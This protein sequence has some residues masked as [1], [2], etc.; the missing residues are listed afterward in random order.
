METKVLD[1]NTRE[2]EEKLISL[3]AKKVFDNVR[4]ITHFNNS[5]ENREP[6][7]KL[8]EE[9]EKL[10]L[11]SQNHQTR[12]E[13]KLFVSRKVECIELLKT[14]GYAP[15]SEVKVRRISFEWEGIDFD[16]DEFP[17]IPA[18]LE[19]DLGDSRYS[20]DDILGKL[21]LKENE[22]GEMSTIDIYNNYGLNYFDLF[23]L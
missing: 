2:L 20:L 3:G 18:F 10:K 23:K 13:T 8:T 14:L 4:V 5:Q 17:Q 6:F 7:L 9:G 16:I 11:S 1:I 19:I 22:R 15:V 21:N 12:K